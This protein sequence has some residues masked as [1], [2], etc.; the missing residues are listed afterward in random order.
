MEG[1]LP[2]LK[3]WLARAQAPVKLK[4]CFVFLTRVGRFHDI[5]TPSKPRVCNE[6]LCIDYL[7]CL[8]PPARAYLL[9]CFA[10]LSA[11]ANT[12]AEDSA[13]RITGTTHPPVHSCEAQII[14]LGG[15]RR[16]GN[17][18]DSTFNFRWAVFCGCS[19]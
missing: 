7:F 18:V 10:G 13:L 8:S 12:S 6:N 3:L 17:T 2:L 5:E 11:G 1:V 19:L 4:V 9:S 16:F 15:N 14:R